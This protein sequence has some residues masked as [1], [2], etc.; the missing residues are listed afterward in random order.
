MDG[1]AG[2][3]AINGECETITLSPLSSR[4]LER[5]GA[6]TPKAAGASVA[7][8]DTDDLRS[9]GCG[10]ALDWSE[11]RRVDCSKLHIEQYEVDRIASGTYVTPGRWDLSFEV[12][13]GPLGGHQITVGWSSG[14]FYE[15]VT[16]PRGDLRRLFIFDQDILALIAGK[17]PQS[18]RV[19]EFL[20]RRD[21]G[22][23]SYLRVLDL[24]EAIRRI[25][26]GPF[27]RNTLAA[28]D[29]I[30][31]ACPTEEP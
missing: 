26:P 14:T 28:M 17:Q 9:F 29:L 23:A 12:S 15:Q 20:E 22:A 11:G 30:L 5:R 6:L 19:R 10:V 18:R 27:E 7:M 25:A 3:V 21:R 4:G 1:E 13:H 8:C 31:E 2:G 24:F 16:G